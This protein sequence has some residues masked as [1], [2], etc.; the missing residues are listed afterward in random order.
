MPLDATQAAPAAERRTVL[1]L[2]AVAEA[3]MGAAAAFER[4]PTKGQASGRISLSISAGWPEDRSW[5]RPTLKAALLRVYES[6][7]VVSQRIPLVLL[8]RLGRDSAVEMRRRACDAVIET[9]SPLFVYAQTGLAIALPHHDAQN[10][11]VVGDPSVLLRYNQVESPYQVAVR[12]A[13]MRVLDALAQDW[14]AEGPLWRTPNVKGLSGH[15]RLNA[16]ADLPD[17]VVQALAAYEAIR[18]SSAVLTVLRAGGLLLA[19]LPRKAG[20]PGHR[21]VDLRRI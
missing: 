19:L 21:L 4:R 10:T 7:E 6:D 8:K 12:D 20:L 2:R 5:R 18:K 1:A 13:R 17:T 3:A 16:Y 14:P 11:Q 9:S 15:A